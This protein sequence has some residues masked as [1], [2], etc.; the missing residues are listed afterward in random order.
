MSEEGLRKTANKL[1]SVAEPIEMDDE[2]FEKQLD[3]L[4][5]AAYDEEGDIRAAIAAI[6]PT[7]HPERGGA[8]ANAEVTSAAEAHKQADKIDATS[9][10]E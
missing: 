6:V 9:T 10:E 1:I 3:A 4:S 5:G 8:E 2:V 7:F